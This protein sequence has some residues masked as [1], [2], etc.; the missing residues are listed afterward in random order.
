[1]HIFISGDGRERERKKEGDRMNIG[2]Y[3]LKRSIFKSKDRK[4]KTLFFNNFKGML[5]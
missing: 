1:M 2:E 5:F 3:V 4:E